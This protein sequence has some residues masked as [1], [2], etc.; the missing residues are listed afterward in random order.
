LLRWN[1]EFWL[2]GPPTQMSTM[3]TANVVRWF[4]EPKIDWAPTVAKPGGS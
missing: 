3:P 2:P 1:S 4:T